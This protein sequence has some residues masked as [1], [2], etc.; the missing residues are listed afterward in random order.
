M[1]VSQLGA[2]LT[3]QIV[4]GAAGSPTKPGASALVRKREKWD[5]QAENGRKFSV[6]N[7][8]GN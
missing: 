1:I 3:N 7:S 2:W 6:F 8:D 5:Q 4:F